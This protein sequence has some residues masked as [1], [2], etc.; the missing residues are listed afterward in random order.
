MLE[1]SDKQILQAFNPKNHGPDNFYWA[2]NNIS[3]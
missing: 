2:E 1:H 3:L